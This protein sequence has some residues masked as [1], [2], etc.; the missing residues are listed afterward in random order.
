MYHYIRVA[1]VQTDPLGYRLSVTPDLFDRQLAAL[2]GAGYH[3]ITMAQLMAGQTGSDKVV[4]TFDDGYEDFYTAA[5]PVLQKYGATATA[6]II[7]NKIGGPYMTWDQLRQAKAD[8]VE[9]GAHTADHLDLSKLSVSRQQ[10]EIEG[11]KRVLESNLGG[12]VTA[13]CY[14]SGR[15]DA[16]TLRLV[17]QDGFA[18]ATTTNPGAV[19]SLSQPFTL[20]RV[21]VTQQMGAD[22]LLRSLR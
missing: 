15:Y 18:S 5:L 10:A 22:D 1:N 11:S 13:F 17:R 7:T 12:P 21:R 19:Y 20:N 14:P 6:Y 8:G 4:L 3:F 16:D 2:K 9:I